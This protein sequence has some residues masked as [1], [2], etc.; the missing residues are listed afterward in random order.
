MCVGRC[1]RLFYCLCGCGGTRA[2][3]SSYPIP[4]EAPPS[5]LRGCGQK[6]E[7]KL[8]GHERRKEE[9]KLRGH[10]RRKGEVKLKGRSLSA[11]LREACSCVEG[12]NERE[13]KA[14]K[15]RLSLWKTVGFSRRARGGFEAS[16]RRL[17][18]KVQCVE[19]VTLEAPLVFSKRA[20]EGGT[21]LDLPEDALNLPARRVCILGSKR[22]GL[23]VES[24]IDSYEEVILP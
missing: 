7:V 16:E 20:N 12:A 11:S 3:S 19:T 18:K 24:A 6:E 21:V 17:R 1:K 22:G 23:H 13:K 15:K 8:R 10:E 4:G 2:P 5:R 14:S 9:V